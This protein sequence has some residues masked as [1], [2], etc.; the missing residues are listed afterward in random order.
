MC[1]LFDELEEIPRY[2]DNYQDAENRKKQF[3]TF[4]WQHP[5]KG[6]ARILYELQ[7]EPSGNDFFAFAVMKI[8][9]Y[10]NLDPLVE[11][12]DRQYG[13]EG[14]FQKDY[15]KEWRIKLILQFHS[16]S[17]SAISYCIFL[18]SMLNVA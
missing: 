5:A 4:A 1:L 13:E 14:F 7:I 3:T 6:H 16:P 18:A 17:S 12:Q 2:P 8:E 10:P 9:F 11:N 15:S